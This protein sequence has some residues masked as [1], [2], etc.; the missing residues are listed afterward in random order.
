MLDM[1]EHALLEYCSSM[2]CSCA[3]LCERNSE[4]SGKVGGGKKEKRLI[5][6]LAN[7]PG[8]IYTGYVC[9]EHRGRIT[10]SRIPPPDTPAN[11][12]RHHTPSA[13]PQR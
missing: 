8:T 12:T 4:E 10:A 13:L 9:Q 7:R 1:L 2:L 11:A 6:G 5:H 3:T